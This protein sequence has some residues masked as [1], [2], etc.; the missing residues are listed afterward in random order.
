MSASVSIAAHP[1]STLCRPLSISASAIRFVSMTCSDDEEE[2][3]PVCLTPSMMLIG[4]GHE[5]MLMN[6][7]VSLPSAFLCS[8]NVILV[9]GFSISRPVIS[10][11]VTGTCGLIS[12]SLFPPR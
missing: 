9:P 10:M 2:T 3:P 12:I 1:L 4:D 7:G 8:N 11:M 6:C 5:E